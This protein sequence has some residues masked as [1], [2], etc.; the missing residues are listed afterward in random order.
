MG[1]D[2]EMRSSEGVAGSRRVLYAASTFGHL[3]SFHLPYIE[4]LRDEG[5]TVVALAGGDP[6]GM[7]RGVRC[8][9]EPFTKSMTAPCNAAVVRDVA[10]LVRREGFDEVLVHTSLAAFFVRLGVALSG[11]RRGGAGGAY[12]ADG[13]CRA[14]GAH[15]VAR[16]GPRVVNTVHGYLFD[17]ATPVAKRTLLLGAERL[18]AGVTDDIVTM[19]AQDTE[20][21]VG[22]RLCRGRVVQVDGMGVDLARCRVAGPSERERARREL[23]IPA[24]AFVLLYAAEFSP[25]KNQAMLVDAM[26]GLPE[27]VVLA[28]PGRGELL[29]ACRGRAERLGVA[30]RVWMP[31]YVED[32][33]VWRAAADLCV[34][35]SRYE[36]LPFH[37]VEAMACGL[38]LVLSAVKGHEDLVGGVGPCGGG[39]RGGAGGK[40]APAARGATEWQRC[41]MLYPFGD[42]GAFRTCVLRLMDDAALRDAM[43]SAAVE[44][45]WRYG[46]DRVMGTLMEL[47]R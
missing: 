5:C 42:V 35:A 25:R 15:G 39:D 38:P 33:S 37:A 17:A 8:V 45:A 7:P 22:H 6:S 36:G 40:G 34:S 19:N 24:D 20:I 32:L 44:C 47:Y 28:L 18:V 11:V 46:R 12:R 1:T 3:R 21:A 23:G 43:V 16:R 27:R 41:G 10:A 4:A 2:C 29:E 26:A 31:G 9:V 13:V 30:G 14:D